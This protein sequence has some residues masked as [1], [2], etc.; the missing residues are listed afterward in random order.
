MAESTF[1]YFDL[2][3]SD[4]LFVLCQLAKCH[5]PNVISTK[6]AFFVMTNAA[7]AVDSSFTEVN[8]LEWNSL[9]VSATGFEIPVDYILAFN[10]S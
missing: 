3:F 7:R 10:G 4:F 9:A 2:V 5:V 8:G 6:L 1:V